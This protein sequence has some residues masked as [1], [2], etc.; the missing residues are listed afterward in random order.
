MEVTGGRGELLGRD[1]KRMHVVR[2]ADVVAGVRRT[3]KDDGSRTETRQMEAGSTPTLSATR[4]VV[5]GQRKRRDRRKV[6][7]TVTRTRDG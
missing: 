6:T 5:T 4:E 7:V 1:T 3:V 2:L